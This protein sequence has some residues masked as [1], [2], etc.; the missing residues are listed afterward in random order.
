LTE[1]WDAYIDDV[2]LPESDFIAEQY[3]LTAPS[4]FA[5]VCARKVASLL[6][7]GDECFNMQ[8]YRKAAKYYSRARNLNPED[9]RLLWMVLRAY[10]YA[11]DTARIMENAYLLDAHPHVNPQLRIAALNI[12]GNLHW[13]MGDYDEALEIFRDILS[14]HINIRW[15]AR[16]WLKI[17]ILEHD[18]LRHRLSDIL[19]KPLSDRK[20]M[21]VLETAKNDYPEFP[22]VLYLLGEKLFEE[23]HFTLA[24]DYCEAA[25]ENGL[26]HTPLELICMEMRG[27]SQY[28]LGN[29]HRAEETFQ[30]ILSKR[31]IPE[32]VKLLILDWIERCHFTK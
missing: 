32:G 7:R 27:I 24:A 8:R 18:E 26:H 6:N 9:P 13:R 25:C 12:L 1:E 19:T 14:H 28:R 2:A 21:V 30:S 4:I 23:N 29:I 17:R 11:G 15:D 20:T 31:N 3:R 10:Y 5:K 16:M 22:P